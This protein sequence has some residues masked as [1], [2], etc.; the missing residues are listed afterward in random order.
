M[1][2]HCNLGYAAEGGGIYAYD[3]TSSLRR[4]LLRRCTGRYG[5]GAKIELG[6]AEFLNCSFTWNYANGGA[7]FYAAHCGPVVTEYVFKRNASFQGSAPLM[8]TE[9]SPLITGCTFTV[10]SRE[11]LQYVIAIFTSAEERPVISNCTVTAYEAWEF[12]RGLIGLANASPLIERCILA[13]SHEGTAVY[14][15]GGVCNPEVTNCVVFGNAGGDSL[16]GYHHDNLFVDPLF[17]DLEANDVGLC[18]NSPAL[19]AGNP[20]RVSIGAHGATC[21][22]CSTPVTPMSWGAIT[23][24]YR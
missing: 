2:C 11:P 5:G 16:I 12:R 18:S 6:Q 14:D 10:D 9:S 23:A 7:P 1:D 13:F 20:W 19:P 17:C 15:A 8:M 24:L 21:G 3:S 22:D 4:C